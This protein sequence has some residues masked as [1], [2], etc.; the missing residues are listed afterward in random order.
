VQVLQAVQDAALDMVL[1]VDPAEQAT[2]A[3]FEVAEQAVDARV[4]AEHVVQVVQG[5]VPDVVVLYLPAA[6]VRHEEPEQYLPAGQE[7]QASC[8]APEIGEYP[9]ISVAC[10]W[11]SLPNA[12]VAVAAAVNRSPANKIRKRLTI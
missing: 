11:V 1:K 3:R 12:A 9:T 8:R 6:H 4:P 5:A 2:Q 7:A 10:I